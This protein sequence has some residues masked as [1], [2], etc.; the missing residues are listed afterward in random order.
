MSDTPL[1]SDTSVEARAVQLA[2]LRSMT[3]RQRIRQTCGLSQQVRRMAF[4]AIRRRWPDLPE[5][6]VQLRFIELTYGKSLADDVRHS[7]A[8]TGWRAG[9]DREAVQDGLS[10]TDDLVDAL[11]PVVSAFRRLGVRH[12]VGGSVASSFHGAT[13]TTMDVDLVCELTEDQ[14]SAFVACFDRD[15][16]VSEP[17]VRGAVRRKSCFNLIHLPTSFKIDVF[18]SRGRPYD[19]ESMRRATEQRLGEGHHVQVRIASAEDSIVSKLEWYRLTNETSD[20][21]WDDVSRL[22][23]LLGDTADFDYMKRAAESLGVADLLARLL[24]QPSS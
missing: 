15:F 22:I 14:I 11:S 1:V 18:V 21:Q 3:P 6:E 7:K 12:F 20:R 24:S 17:A 4:A 9:K 8:E 19:L 23:Q 10:D 13:R 16:Y 5:E 2:C